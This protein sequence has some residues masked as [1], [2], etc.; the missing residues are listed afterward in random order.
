MDSNKVVFVIVF[1]IAISIRGIKMSSLVQESIVSISYTSKYSK[2]WI[3]LKESMKFYTDFFSIKSGSN[4]SVR[5]F[6]SVALTRDTIHLEILSLVRA[7]VSL[8][9]RKCGAP[10]PYFCVTLSSPLPYILLTSQGPRKRG[11][12]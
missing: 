3:L 5:S 2:Q 7:I 11:S 4:F 8:S 6:L 12:T 1:N 9:N 10:S